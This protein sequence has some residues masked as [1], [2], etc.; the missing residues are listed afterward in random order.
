M[1]PKKQLAQ[2]ISKQLTDAIQTAGVVTPGKKLK[3]LVKKSSKRIAS[4]VSKKIEKKK[5]VRSPKAK[6]PE[7]KA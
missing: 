2:L 7:A 4:R 6:A 5:V 1:K 3:K